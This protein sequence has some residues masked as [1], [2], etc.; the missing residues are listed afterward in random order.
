MKILR[1]KWTS[2]VKFLIKEKEVIEGR[3]INRINDEEE[4][5]QIRK[6]RKEGFEI[7]GGTQK[8]NKFR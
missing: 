8:I 2:K 3:K 7:G 4:E 1:T 5:N 6:Q